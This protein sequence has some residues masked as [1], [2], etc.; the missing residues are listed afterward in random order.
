MSQ[1]PLYRNIETVTHGRSLI[2]PAGSPAPAGVLMAFHGYAQSADWMLT[3]LRDIPELNHSWHICSLHAL[4]RFYQPKSGE[5]V[6]SW[7]TSQDREWMIEDNLRYVGRA[8]ADFKDCIDKPGR[9]LV[10]VGFSQG[11]AMAWRAAARFLVSS[12]AIIAVGG[13]IPPDVHVA[14]FAEWNGN[15]L[16]AR[17]KHD[18]V[19]SA[20]RLQNDM[21]KLEGLENKVELAEYNGSHELNNDFGRVLNRFLESIEL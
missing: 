15:I 4:H 1:P 12:R 3:M 18:R 9:H 13:D 21:E 20:A 14:S 16:V 5:I 11:A 17:G 7:M 10:F 6:G 19:Y 2:A 8:M